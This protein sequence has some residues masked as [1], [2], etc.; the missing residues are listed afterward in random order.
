MSGV[1]PFSDGTFIR[2]TRLDR[3]ASSVAHLIHPFSI[4]KIASIRI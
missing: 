2:R 4:D 1:F 3:L